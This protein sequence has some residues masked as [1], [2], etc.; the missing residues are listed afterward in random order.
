MEVPNGFS[1]CSVPAILAS[2]YTTFHENGGKVSPQAVTCL[3]TMVGGKHGHTSC[4]IP[5][6]QKI[7]FIYQLNFMEIIRLNQSGG[8]SEHLQ[9]FGIIP[10]SKQVS[11]CL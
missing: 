8:K 7:M 6:V 11:I 3:K 5:S 9:F 4:K 2:F 1:G 10:N